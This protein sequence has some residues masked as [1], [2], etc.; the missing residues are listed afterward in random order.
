[1]SNA[2]HPIQPLI[3]DDNGVLRF[4]KNEIVRHLLD[5]ATEGGLDLNKIAAMR[6]SNEDRQQF[7]QLI[8]Y[9]LGGYGDLSYV[10][11]DA[12]EAASAMEKADNS[13][14]ARADSLQEK[15]DRLKNG[16]RIVVADLFGIH[17]EDLK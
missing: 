17:P 10:D 1:M 2:K 9:S 3:L 15:M 12:Y 8:G 13:D 14:K 11:D 6:F 4:K 7:S 16:M 5:W